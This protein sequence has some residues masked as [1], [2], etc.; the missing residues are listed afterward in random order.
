MNIADSFIRWLSSLP[1]K[2]ATQRAAGEIRSDEEDVLMEVGLRVMG[3]SATS[4]EWRTW[5][6]EVAGWGS[7]TF[8]DRL[9]EF[10]RRHPELRG[11]RWP[12]DPYWLDAQ[13][14]EAMAERVSEFRAA[15]AHRHL[16]REFAET[17]RG[18][19]ERPEVPRTTP[20]DPPEDELARLLR[21]LK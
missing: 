7:T 20:S 5:M 2:A 6:H 13:P 18:E 17:V 9:K 3:N 4:G 21:Q 15:T 10:K 8:D 14:S 19:L 1:A 12:F 16:C 11:C